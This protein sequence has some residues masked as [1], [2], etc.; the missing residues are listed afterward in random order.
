MFHSVCTSCGTTWAVSPTNLSA[1]LDWLAPRSANG[2]VIK[3][4][5]EVM[6]AGSGPDT[7][8]PSSS[9]ACN[10]GACGSWYTGPVTVSLSA[11]D[12]GS[13]VAGI[14]YATDGSDPAVTGTTYTGPFPLSSTSTVR[15][16]ATDL[17]GNVEP[18]RSKTVG[19]DTVDPTVSWLTPADGASV[20]RG[21]S[22]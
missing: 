5:G 12:F 1:L 11:S 16:Y 4:V 15:W 10:G 19:I 8:P 6:G 13:G 20:P 21:T 7:T 2:T 18:A 22:R 17:A 14:R 9:I 3:T